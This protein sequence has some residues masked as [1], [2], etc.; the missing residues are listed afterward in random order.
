MKVLILSQYHPE[1]VRGGAQQV[2][3][4]LFEGLKESPGMSPV[5]LAAIDPSFAALY[6]A[7]ACITGFDGRSREFLFLSRAYDYE[8]HKTTAP[9]LLEAY[10]GFLLLI[11]PDVVHFHHFMLFGID[12]L[13]LTRRTLPNCRIVFTLHEFL[14]ICAADG[15]MVRRQDS[16]LCTGASPVRCHQCFPDQAP[17][18]FFLRRAWFNRHFEVVDQFTVPGRFMV[19][20]FVDWGLEQSRISCVT[21]GQRDYSGGRRIEDRRDTRNRFGFFGQLVD[22]KGVWLLLEAVRILRAESFTDFFIELNG[23]NLRFASERRRLEIEDFL[24]AE[25]ELPF[26]RRL[27]FFNGAYAVDQ[28]AQRMA[29]VDWCIFPSVWWEAF[30]LVVSEAKMFGRPVI[31]ADVGAPA[32]RVHDGIDGLH[33]PVGDARALAAAIRR[34]ATEPGLWAA[35]S[36][37][38]TAPPTR[39]SMVEQFRAVYAQPGAMAPAGTDLAAE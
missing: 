2:A 3:Y 23:D 36:A 33:F 28:L 5:F 9:A 37:N 29:R 24:H 30:G 22:V 1:L 4:E 20:R 8:W 11:R 31:C 21:N 25:A 35:L 10:I 16:T 18:R 6:K 13:T 26:D 14:S 12:L 34:A 39:C 27:V 15:H 19:D 32:E 7:N 38:I 17:E